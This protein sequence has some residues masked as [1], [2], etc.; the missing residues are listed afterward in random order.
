MLPYVIAFN[1]PAIE[2]RLATLA[3]TLNL[4]SSGYA[5]VIAWLLELRSVIGIPHKADALGLTEE[6]VP[7]LSEMAAC[8]LNA[9]ENPV[10]L[11]APDAADIYRNALHGRLP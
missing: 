11:S 5:G 6:L 1:R 8:D 3:R 9:P 2:E 10:P 4:P 7:E